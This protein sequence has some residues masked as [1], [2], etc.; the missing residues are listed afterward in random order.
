[1]LAT[2]F[3]D[4]PEIALSQPGR[5]R[6]VFLAMQYGD[7]LAGDPEQR[8]LQQ[9]VA[10][11]AGGGV[12]QYTLRVSGGE[13]LVIRTRTPGAGPGEPINTLN[14]RLE[15]YNEA[16]LLVGTNDDSGLDGLNALVTT[17]VPAGTSG[18]YRVVVVPVAGEGDYVLSVDGLLL[19][20]GAHPRVIVSQPADGA[21][22]SLSPGAIDLVFSDG[23]NPA[24]VAAT[25]LTI[26][27]GA[28]VV[29]AHSS[30]DERFVS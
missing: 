27:G 8:I 5:G 18:L 13:E 26:D 23:I 25:D 15:V 20:Q 21:H 28:T 17:S 4:R 16:G 19:S 11:A 9:A 10:Y 7:V 14:P 30:M 2:G 12:D 24:S 1:M 3:E 22:V 6:S 29:G